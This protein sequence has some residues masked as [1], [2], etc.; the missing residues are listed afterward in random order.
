M[1]VIG[2]IRTSTEEQGLGLEAQRA[3]I[4]AYCGLYGH[5]LV[6]IESDQA[7]G[8]SMARP[9]LQ[10]ALTAKADGIIVAKLDRLTRSVVDLGAILDGLGSRALVSVGE[11]VDTSSAA[12]RLVLNLLTSVAQWEREAISERTSAA[13]QAKRAKGE[14]AGNVPFGF[15]A[16]ADGRL[17]EHAAEQLIIAR[18]IELRAKGMS[19]R[20][21]ERM[22]ACEGHVSRSGKPLSPTQIV[23]ICKTHV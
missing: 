3:R 2:Y 5:E 22:L 7:S 4:E 12:G 14:R 6:S 13:L 18:C 21:I 17:R 9:G 15:E 11:Q 23:R 10:R 1:K 20:A 8:R 16:D 19:F